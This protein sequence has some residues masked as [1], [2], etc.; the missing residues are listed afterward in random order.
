MRALATLH[1]WWGVAFCLL[2]IMWF[3]S[4]IVMHFVPLPAR[5]ERSVPRE[6]AASRAST[7]RID[8]DQWTVAGDF[9][10]DRPL[11]RIALDDDAGTEIYVSAK[12]GKVVLTTTRN[13]RLLNYLGS[14]AHWIYPTTLRHHR[15]VWVA[16]IWCLSL[17]ATIGAA[18]GVLIGFVRLRVGTPYRGLQS[19][20][21]FFGLIFAPF[22]LAWIFSGFLSMDD[23]WLLPRSDGLF[24]ALHTLDFPPLASHPWLRTSVIVG[25]CL[26]GCA[27]SLTGTVLAWQLL[28]NGARVSIDD[29]T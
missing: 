20:H 29:V 17:L 5:S 8:Y 24:R 13:V 3:A 18:L 23:G 26:C 9:D 16:L 25:L 1:R 10:R 6:I 2:F 22:L 14:I 28:R 11:T 21:H 12:S 27:F 4:G 7:E 15:A 19:W